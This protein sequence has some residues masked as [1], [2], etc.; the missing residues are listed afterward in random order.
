MWT[1]T[2]WRDAAER[3]I[4]TAAQSAI[5]L[6]GADGFDLLEVDVAAVFGVA[7]GGALLSLLKSLVASKVNDPESASLVDLP[8]RHA[9]PEN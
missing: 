1:R 6:L 4:A 7:A 5:A 3:C 9:H 2:F 8:G